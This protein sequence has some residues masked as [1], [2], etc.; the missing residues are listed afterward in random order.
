MK[1]TS[2]KLL[3]LRNGLLLVIVVLLLVVS[4]GCEK[5][6]SNS[7][8]SKSGQVSTPRIPSAYIYID[9][10]PRGATVSLISTDENDNS[11][12]EVG[13]TPLTLKRSQVMNRRV[14]LMMRVDELVK[15]MRTVPELANEVTK[16][17]LAS[18]YGTPGAS[19]TLFV[20]RVSESRMIQTMQGG[21]VGDGPVLD[22]D[23]ETNRLCASFIPR[24][25]DI[26]KFYPLM[27]PKGM[28]MAGTTEWA[29]ACVKDY[30]MSAT[31]AQVAAECLSRC[32]YYQ[33]V[34]FSKKTPGYGDHLAM[35]A[36]GEP[37]AYLY[38][39]IHWVGPAYEGIDYEEAF[40]RGV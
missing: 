14:L 15:Q 23:D 11:E 21:L 5:K 10:V 4:V 33:T 3:G 40:F 28:F 13:K 32:G 2:P 27:P 18:E 19:Q 34:V 7:K 9:S 6:D 30:G 17:S 29:K 31:E 1:A 35:T 38:S 37:G 39:V 20:F 25:M 24:G 36:F 16:V 12:Q 8:G 26:K 22:V